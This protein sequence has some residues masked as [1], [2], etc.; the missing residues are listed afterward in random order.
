MQGDD[1]ERSFEDNY[2]MKPGDYPPI[3]AFR[4]PRRF[5]EQMH[6]REYGIRVVTQRCEPPFLTAA[7]RRRTSKESGTPYVET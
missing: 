3:T 7:A 2:F 4:R 1:E 5:L 6:G